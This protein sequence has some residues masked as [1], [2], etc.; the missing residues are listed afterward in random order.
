MQNGKI[1]YG[2]LISLLA[3]M[4]WSQA[5]LALD[6]S[7]RGVYGKEQVSASF[8]NLE[9]SVTGMLSIG[10]ER[11]LLQADGVDDGYSGQL[12]NLVTGKALGVHVKVKD[13]R[14]RVEVQNGA[15][16]IHFELEKD[17]D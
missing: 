12:H 16:P 13:H 4:C 10:G 2:L 7:Y 1:V 3:G 8:D 17:K 15:E 14:I 6:G 11:Y 5:V 9:S